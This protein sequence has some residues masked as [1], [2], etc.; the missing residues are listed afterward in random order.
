MGKYLVLWEVDQTKIPMDP[1]ERG[2]GWGALMAM[3][4]QDLEKGNVKDWGAFVGETGGYNISEGSEVE[5]M[6]IHQQYVPFITFKVYPVATE[7]QTNEM[8]KALSG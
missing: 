3:V 6:K 8:I 4:R 2:A 7:D 5:I 1:K